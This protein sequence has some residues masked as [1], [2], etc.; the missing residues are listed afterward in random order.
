MACLVVFFKMFYDQFNWLESEK[1]EI[2]PLAQSC[3]T[4]A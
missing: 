2:L 1:G 3:L 4:Y